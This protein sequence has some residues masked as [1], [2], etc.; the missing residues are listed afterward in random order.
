[1]PRSALFGAAFVLARASAAITIAC[2]PAPEFQPLFAIQ[3]TGNM[4][5]LGADVC[6]SIPIDDNN[7]KHLYLFGDTLVGRFVA[8]G[9]NGTR[10]WHA[11]PRNS[12]GVLLTKEGG[13]PLTTLS[14][15]WRIDSKNAQHVGF[16]SPPENAS[17]WYWPQ[18]GLRVLNRSY[19]IGWRMEPANDPLFAFATAGIDVIALP[20]DS[21]SYNSPL[22]W[23]VPFVTTTI[24]S[25]ISNNFTIGNAVAYDESDGF[26]YLLGG[27]GSPASAIMARISGASFVAQRW[28]ELAFLAEDGATWIP[29]APT[30][31]LKHL[32]GFVP[33]ECTLTY[34]PA[35]SAWA[36]V[37]ANTFL[38]N[39]ITLQTAPKP[40]GP[41][42]PSQNIYEIPPAM[43][44]AG[45]FCFAAKVHPELSRN[46][47]S[48][49]VFTYNCNT[50][51][52]PPLLTLPQ[53]YVPNVIRAT[54]TSS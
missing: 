38:G 52:I 29:Y 18:V 32:F 3:S 43:R 37:T 7:R 14:H 39:S 9:A 22:D 36:I 50:P 46:S 48:E 11:M 24:G 41:F 27:E 10:Q 45:A 34:V 28:S 17:Q 53:I 19:V 26:V 54:V 31:K 44:E 42:S 4:S 49:F 8:S 35:L 15:E 30:N 13:V 47:S 5:W 21:D 2:A 51:G 20:A 12:V 25:Y 16:F 6:T 1:M 23:P 40:Y 33:S